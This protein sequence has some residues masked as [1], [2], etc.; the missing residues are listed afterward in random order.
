VRRL[1]LASLALLALLVGAG[2]ASADHQD[3]ERKLTRADN[4][5]A[6]AMLITST[7]LPPGFQ[8]Q[9]DRSE[10]PH[11]ACSP[12]VSES[13]LTL[14]GEAEGRQF[15][16]GPVFVSSA[17]QV[18]ASAG[19]ADASWRRGTSTAG[20]QCARAVLRREFAKQ[21]IDVL[22]LREIPFPRV[23]QRTVAYRV[24]VRATTPQGA[25]LLFLDVVAMMHTRAHAT[26]V[27]GTP[28]VPPQRAD[29]LRFARLVAGRMAT[30]MRG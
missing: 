10:D 18:W 12:S 5:R 6:R 27:V 17:A 8:A 22:S 9:V 20:V 28:L 29:E 23:A 21:G 16:L 11:V 19:D 1:V 4:A 7:D 30:A 15:A 3:P 14:T 13:D 25:V 24:R 2:A 26:V